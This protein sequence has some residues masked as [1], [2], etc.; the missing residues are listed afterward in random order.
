MPSHP[1]TYGPGA[2]LDDALDTL[3]HA[4]RHA[5][6]PADEWEPVEEAWEE[7]CGQLDY[8]VS[9]DPTCLHPIRTNMREAA[10]HEIGL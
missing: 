6:L 5:T 3:R 1:F 9:S 8:E 4:L 7:V 2:T 10:D